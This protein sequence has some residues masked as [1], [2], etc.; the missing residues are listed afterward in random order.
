MFGFQCSVRKKARNSAHGRK[1]LS[2]LPTELQP[3]GTKDRISPSCQPASARIEFACLREEITAGC[4]KRPYLTRWR[5]WT[6]PNGRAV[7]LHRFSCGDW[8][9]D[10]HN[11]RKIFGSIGLCGGYVEETVAPGEAALASRLPRRRGLLRRAG[12]S[13]ALLPGDCGHGSEAESALPG[14]K[15]V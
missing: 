3:Q 5:L 2:I 14:R 15:V 12:L 9:R 8:A 7:Y 6:G 10:L 13:N 11:H 4:A 1:P